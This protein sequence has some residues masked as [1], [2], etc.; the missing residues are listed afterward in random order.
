[1]V[2]VKFND[3]EVYSQDDQQALIFVIQELGRWFNT[4]KQNPITVSI[5]KAKEETPVAEEQAGPAPSVLEINVADN[6]KAESS[7]A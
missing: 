2:V 1:M 6:I 4:D 3:A 5:S 7:M